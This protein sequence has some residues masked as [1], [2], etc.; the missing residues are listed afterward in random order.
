MNWKKRMCLEMV[1]SW[2][3]QVNWGNCGILWVN[4]A[5]VCV[6]DDWKGLFWDLLYCLSKLRSFLSFPSGMRSHSK[7]AQ[8][9]WDWIAPFTAV[10]SR[11]L[12][13]SLLQTAATREALQIFIALQIRCCSL[14]VTTLP[15]IAAVLETRNSW[16]HANLPRN[17]ALHIEIAVPPA[18]L[19]G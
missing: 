12:C 18:E 2:C 3:R 6:K 4:F 9:N 7:I 14:A 16:P 5:A 17:V 11:K 15:C 10:S 13:F 8:F 19:M 1:P